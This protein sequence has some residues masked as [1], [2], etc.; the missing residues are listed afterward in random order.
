M[1]TAEA[2]HWLRRQ[3]R[4]LYSAGECDAI[5]AWVFEKVTGLSRAERL[6]QRDKPLH[7]EQLHRLTAIVKQLQA[8]QPVQYIL[9]ESYFYGMLLY[10]DDNVLIP[11]PETEE[12]VHWI[13]QDV[14]AA[15][16]DVFDEKTN[17]ADKTNSL[18]ILDVGTGSGCIALALKNAMP[19]AEVWGCDSS[20]SALN[21]A[22]RN[23]AAL[24]IRV[25]FQS[26]DFL[27]GAQWAGLPMFDIIVSNPPYI[28]QKESD[29]MPPHVVRYEPHAALFVPDEAPLLFYEALALFG[30]EKL[31]DGG[32]VYVEIHEDRGSDVV[33][34]FQNAMYAYVQLMKDMQGKDRMVRALVRH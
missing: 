15:R 25:D 23:G 4:T 24:D 5:A 28:T 6:Q 10:I 20:D 17:A 3:L 14:K 21:V 32:A 9:E 31:H 2:E 1:K 30:K 11:R 12:L 26:L 29:S 13:V 33:Q 18:R 34:L 7:A 8:H 27:D 19:K 22:R 16:K